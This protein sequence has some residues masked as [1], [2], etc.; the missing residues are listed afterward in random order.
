M[1]TGHLWGQP[2]RSPVE[3]T[4]GTK[5]WGSQHAAES[6]Q[7]KVQ[8][9]AWWGR[10]G[11]L[12]V[13]LGEWTWIQVCDMGATGSNL[14][15]GHSSGLQASCRHALHRGLL[16]TQT[17]TFHLDEF[18]CHRERQWDLGPRRHPEPSPARPFLRMSFS[19]PPHRP[20]A[21][22]QS[23][24]RALASLGTAVGGWMCCE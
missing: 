6:R 10:H 18:C 13:G 12:Q 17:G 20:E 16:L 7:D 19:L 24:V 8:H 14:R 15:R 2:G 1:G 23:Q 4:P 22:A 21:Q 11:E 9:R 5:S 3:G